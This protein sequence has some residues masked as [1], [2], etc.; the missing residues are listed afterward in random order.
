[1]L[2][3]KLISSHGKVI[4]LGDMVR[5]SK[6]WSDDHFVGILTSVEEYSSIMACNPGRLT[7]YSKRVRNH[8]IERWEPEDRI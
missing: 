6:R 2:Y 4:K 7:R 3:T 8:D 5:A 1:M